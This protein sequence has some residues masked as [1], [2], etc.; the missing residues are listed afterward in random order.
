MFKALKFGNN[1]TKGKI[2]MKYLSCIIFVCFC[3]LIGVFT[4]VFNGENKAKNI[5][6]A[7]YLRIHIRANSNDEEDQNVKYL[8]KDKLLNY[9]TPSVA[10]CETK[11]DLENYFKQNKTK[12]TNF[13]NNIL[14]EEG[15]DYISNIKLNNEYFPTRT[16]N[17][18][19]LENGFYDAIIVELGKA[20]GNN[21]WCV[22]YPPLCFMYETSDFGN[23]TYKSIILELV[24]K[25]FK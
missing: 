22:A 8:I 23:I 5:T 4:L 13:I 2:I 24:N 16:Y 12:I 18:V 6:N 17:G 1:Q 10:N 7:D 21:W 20:E 11:E 25:F 3:V 15:F 14:S 9:I 19:T